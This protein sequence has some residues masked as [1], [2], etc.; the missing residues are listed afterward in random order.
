MKVVVGR[1]IEM[2]LALVH[3]CL[4]D[5]SYLFFLP[6]CLFHINKEVKRVK[7]QDSALKI[8]N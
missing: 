8:V 2:D 7:L 6:K 3:F 1:V 4:V 5:Q